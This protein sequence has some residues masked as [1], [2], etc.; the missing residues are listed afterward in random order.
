[1]IENISLFLGVAVFVG[2]P[3]TY[4]VKS[5]KKVIDRDYIFDIKVVKV[6]GEKLEFKQDYANHELPI[7]RLN[8]NGNRLNFLLDTGANVN[9]IN[10][11]TF[12]TSDIINIV[13]ANNINVEKAA[14]VT[15]GSSTVQ[16]EKTTLPFK[17][18]NKK[19]EEVFRIM[20]MSEPFN[21]ILDKHNIQIH[22]VLGT[23]FFSKYKWSI[24]FDTMV[25]WTK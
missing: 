22:G 11:D 6:K 17:Y 10:K 19:F 23:G 5:I 15:T 14:L 9:I 4:M 1:M 16:T 8:F 21:Y 13:N 3:L 18:G 25:V 20:D 2:L 7:V 12:Y 24:D